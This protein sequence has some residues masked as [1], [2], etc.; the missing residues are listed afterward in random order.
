[1]IKKFKLGEKLKRIFKKQDPHLTELLIEIS[2]NQKNMQESNRFSLSHTQ[3]FNDLLEK[4]KNYEIDYDKLKSIYDI[5]GS[6]DKYST[7]P[8]DLGIWLDNETKNPDT[9]LAIHRTNFPALDIEDLSKC[10][11]LE[12]IMNKGLVNY[13]HI[14]VGGNVGIP[15]VALTMSPLS[16]A[17]DFINLIGSY[18][19]NNVTIIASFPSNIIDDECHFINKN[20]E[21]IQEIYNF[22]DENYSVPFIKP[23]YIIGAL[24]KNEKGIDTFLTRAEL[25]NVYNYKL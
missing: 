21:T 18:K 15:E 24:I 9:T 17:T 23:E 16:T 13:G 6:W 22:E 20:E 12:S 19:D 2:N 14:N 7:V 10:E 3:S 4:A 11:Q 1:M 5:F 8:Y 25:L